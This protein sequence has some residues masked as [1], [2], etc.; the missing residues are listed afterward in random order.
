MALGVEFLEIAIVQL[1]YRLDLIFGCQQEFLERRGQVFPLGAQMNGL[2]EAG[3][4]VTGQLVA[5]QLRIQFLLY[6]PA[7][8][9]QH[10]ARVVLAHQGGEV[11]RQTM[12]DLR[13]GIL[14][15]GGGQLGIRREAGIL[16]G[17][18]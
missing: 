13:E 6:L 7:N 12:G 11:F 15:V 10:F 17:D 18:A 14:E 2:D 16:I 5:G 9:L 4:E 8:A 1:V 3:R